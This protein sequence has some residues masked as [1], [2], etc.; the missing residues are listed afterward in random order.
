MKE[1]YYN[2]E[3]RAP[4]CTTEIE[5]L[6]LQ[7]VLTPRLSWW[8]NGSDNAARLLAE[9]NALAIGYLATVMQQELNLDL[10]VMLGKMQLPEIKH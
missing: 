2:V 1:I 3:V 5:K 6:T 9:K 7:E 8:D 4:G 10:S